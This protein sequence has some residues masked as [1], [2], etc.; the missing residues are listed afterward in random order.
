MEAPEFRSIEF[1][2]GSQ[3]NCSDGVA[4]AGRGRVGGRGAAQVTRL[5]DPHA[6][7][8]QRSVEPVSGEDH[9]PGF[10]EAQLTTLPAA[11]SGPECN[12]TT[13]WSPRSANP[14]LGFYGGRAR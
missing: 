3:E 8:N 7:R 5:S 11:H 1:Y 9:R 12:S 4:T 2:D 6:E 14:W 13:V 10:F